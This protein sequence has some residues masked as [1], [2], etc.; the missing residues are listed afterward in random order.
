MVQEVKADAKLDWNTPNKNNAII[1]GETY[2]VSINISNGMSALSGITNVTL[3]FRRDFNETVFYN[4]TRLGNTSGN[5]SSWSFVLDSRTLTD[6][7]Y[8]LRA[9][10]WQNNTMITL[11]FTNQTA[12][13]IDVHNT[14]PASTY[15][16]STPTD[17]K[18]LDKKNGTV[19]TAVDW[20]VT[21]CNVFFK[22]TSNSAEDYRS[23]LMSLSNGICTVQLTQN[24]SELGTGI[25]YYYFT[26]NDDTN[27]STS[28][29]RTFKLGTIGDNDDDIPPITT[30]TTTNPIKKNAGFIIFLGIIIVIVIIIAIAS[31]QGG[32]N[33]YYYNN[34]Y[35]YA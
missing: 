21:G 26:T 3:E 8:T 5:Q 35:N 7:N 30:T 17:G 15:G 14:V 18:E 24:S 33:S 11:F 22:Q 25:V 19:S 10:A 32:G 27:T 16:T 12:F 23:K 9:R 13:K 34:N 28:A 4:H 1:V 6:G 2:N 29:I 20:S 31:S